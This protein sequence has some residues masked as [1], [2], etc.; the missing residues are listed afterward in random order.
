MKERGFTIVELLVVIIVM[1]ILLTLAVVN[2]RSTQANA[3]DDE[4]I[5]DVENVSLALES[6]YTSNHGGVFRK[7]YPGTLEFNGDLVMNFIK[8]RTGESSL[9]APGVDAEDPISFVVA[10]N[11]NT[12]STGLAPMPTI[13]TYVYQPL[14]SDGTLCPILDGPCQRFN[15]YYRLEKPTDTCPAPENICTYKSKNQ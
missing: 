7:S 3:R 2:V 8:E 10:T 1:A 11:N 9:R 4:R 15:I 6:F 12:P 13:A 5:V 14:R